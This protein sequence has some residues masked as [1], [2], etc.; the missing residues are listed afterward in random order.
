MIDIFKD[1][2]TEEEDFTINPNKVI[3]NVLNTLN[4]KYIDPKFQAYAFILKQSNP[5]SDDYKRFIEL[6]K[7]EHIRS[8]KEYEIRFKN[9]FNSYNVRQLGTIY[10]NHKTAEDIYKLGS[11]TE[12]IVE[13]SI[14]YLRNLRYP[15]E[16]YNKD[17]KSL[18]DL[19]SIIYKNPNNIYVK[20]ELQRI[21]ENIAK[22]IKAS[23][24][25]KQFKEEVKKISLK[26]RNLRNEYHNAKFLISI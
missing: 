16:S 8:K 10:F 7:E 25:Y 2:E 14:N 1:K 22:Q 24:E 20:S 19:K 13:P 12:K 15:S 11:E 9:E 6:I 4:D 17:S 18:K 26:W 3:K 23:S 5:I 21:G